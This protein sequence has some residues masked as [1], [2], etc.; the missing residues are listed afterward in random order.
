METPDVMTSEGGWLD[1]RTA[2]RLQASSEDPSAPLLDAFAPQGDTGWRAAVPGAQTIDVIFNQPRDIRRVRL[3]FEQTRCCT[4]EF[5]VS[6]SD[7]QGAQR[8]IVRQQFTFHEGVER[9]VEDYDVQLHQ[10]E[11]LHIGITPDISGA[12][13]CASLWQCRI[14]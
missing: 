3:V 1:V 6:W 4:H 7:A 5:T 10:A 2:A 13:V 11:A 12:A 8:D 9:E 14:W